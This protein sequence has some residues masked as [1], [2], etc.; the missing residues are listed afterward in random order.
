MTLDGAAPESKKT[1]RIV[2]AAIHPAIGIA[3]IGNSPDEY[4]LGPEVPDAVEAP[5]GGYKDAQGRIKR[6]AVR[7]RVYG[8][9]ARGRV[10]Q[11][12]TLD[13]A[14]IAWT[15]EV[16]NKKSSWYKFA[17]AMDIPEAQPVG[18]RNDTIQGAD[19]SKLEIVPGPRS[20]S[21]P[22]VAGDKAPKFDTG[23][24]FDKSVYLGE[25]QTDPDGRLL[26]FGGLGVSA[27]NDGRPAVS[28][29]NNPGWHDDTSDG[30]VYATVRMN[31]SGRE[32]PVD[33]AWVAV[34]PPDYG[35]GLNDP[36][37]MFDVWE[38]VKHAPGT[39]PT[40]P[41]VFYDHIYPIFERMA[42][43]QWANK[44]FL[45][46]FGKGGLMDF[47]APR[48]LRRLANPSPEW[49]E[50]RT[51]VFHLFRDPDY[52]T[53]SSQALP[54][55]YGDGMDLT[56]QDTRQW[57]ALTHLQYDRLRL[58]AAGTFQ[59]GRP[60]RATQLSEVPLQRRPASMD[61]AQLQACL[62]G[63][64]HPGCELT[65]PMRQPVLYRAGMRIKE[66][67][68]PAPLPPAT[69]QPTPVFGP[70]SCLDGS[71]AGDLSKW[72]AVPWQT[73]TSSCNAGYDASYDEFLPTFWPARV[74]NQVLTQETFQE[75]QATPRDRKR[76]EALFL[77][78]ADWSRI[79]GPSSGGHYQT[80]I[81]NMVT[82]FGELGILERHKVAFGASFPS[83]FLVESRP[84][85]TPL[86]VHAVRMAGHAVNI[87]HDR[88]ARVAEA[89][90]RTTAPVPVASP[91]DAPARPPQSKAA[92]A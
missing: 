66:A 84:R 19:R 50:L 38:N 14:Q 78:R 5:P 25:L 21:G 59:K 51:Q 37:T 72:M 31:G 56:P 39:P 3:R 69:L 91:E 43:T 29:G 16:A 12:L 7:F 1:S 55:I 90:P 20:V 13:D 52:T 10:V 53:M 70:G 85:T 4:F 46:Q 34:A 22:S 73:D 8:Y 67:T 26:F 24:F 81:N 71:R 49:K 42:T 48:M 87:L 77:D 36:V 33:G 68:G 27:S 60:R 86:P 15:V 2:R 83:E 57:L 74:P 64:F 92:K 41:V 65:W 80:H 32:V 17:T 35:P 58:W 28:F 63:A 88:Q 40:E 54:P 11:E 9:D 79:L 82:M 61:Q 45:V 75:M 62:G 47:L 18:L 89:A 6:Q 30:P 44:G 23:R 76:L